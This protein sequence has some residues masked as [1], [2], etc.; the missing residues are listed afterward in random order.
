[1]SRRDFGKDQRGL[2]LTEY[3]ILLGLLVGAAVISVL[4]IGDTL[5]TAWRS[6]D[7]FY[8]LLEATDAGGGGA[9]SAPAGSAPSGTGDGGAGDG[10]AEPVTA[11]SGKTSRLP[12]ENGI[13]HG[14]AERS[15]CGGK[16]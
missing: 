15:H 10:G 6:W 8:G 16:H 3:L 11:G 2:V 7:G 9:G 14:K 1:M 13:L 5:G 4:S 12:C